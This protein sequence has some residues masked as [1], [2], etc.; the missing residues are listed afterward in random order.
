MSIRKTSFLTLFI[1]KKIEKCENFQKLR[2][3][4]WIVF[5]SILYEKNLIGLK[6]LYALALQ[7]VDVLYTICEALA[8]YL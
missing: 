1:K 3:M 2:Y 7:S 6:V 5:K 8:L 4:F